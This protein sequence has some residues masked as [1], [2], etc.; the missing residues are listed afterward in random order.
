MILSVY[1]CKTLIYHYVQCNA[2]IDFGN[3]K[4]SPQFLRFVN[5]MG[6]EIARVAGSISGSRGF[7]DVLRAVATGILVTGDRKGRLFCGIAKGCFSQSV[8]MGERVSDTRTKRGERGLW[9]RRFWDQL[10]RDEADY[11]MHIDYIHWNPVKHGLVK[12]VADWQYSSFRRFVRLGLYPANW[13]NQSVDL[14]DVA[15]EP[16]E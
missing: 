9:Q 3:D 13:G 12:N 2:L 6:A 15:G 11:R 4:H 8:E 10:I 5:Q 7:D 16:R 1:L 14:N